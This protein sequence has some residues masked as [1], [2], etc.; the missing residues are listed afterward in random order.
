LIL[1]V[2]SRVSGRDGGVQTFILRVIPIQ[3]CRAEKEAGAIILKPSLLLH[4]PGQRGVERSTSSIYPVNDGVF[5]ALG[6]IRPG[7]GGT[8]L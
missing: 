8:L 2:G 3:L 5:E 7:A 6:V 1:D 4:G